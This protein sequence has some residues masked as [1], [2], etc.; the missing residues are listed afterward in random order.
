MI[1]NIDKWNTKFSYDLVEE[2]LLCIYE[3]REESPSYPCGIL[4]FYARKPFTSNERKLH[5]L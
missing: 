3:I 4:R 5:Q 2:P 1:Q